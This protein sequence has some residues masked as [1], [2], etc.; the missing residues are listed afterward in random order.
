MVVVTVVNMVVIMVANMAV[1]M[2]VSMVEAKK[3]ME[4]IL[5]PSKK[6]GMDVRQI[7]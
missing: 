7:G 3:A 6:S 4:A 1:V 2:V 5:V